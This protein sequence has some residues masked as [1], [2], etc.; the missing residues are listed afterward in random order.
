MFKRLNMLGILMLL[1]LGC[2]EEETPVNL[3]P[4]PSGLQLKVT[5]S[6][7]RVLIGQ[8]SIITLTIENY[9]P[10]I[11]LDFDCMDHYG[12]EVKQSNGSIDFTLP[13][14]VSDPH[15]YEI[16]R[17]HKETV[18]IPLPWPRYHHP[19]LEPGHYEIYAGFREHRDEY[20]WVKT[21]LV[22]TLP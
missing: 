2:S 18:N 4:P 6:P 17:G 5:A 20:P 8:T 1:V 14:C 15:T 11:V 9:G 13:F 12:I 16:K 19:G 10:D 3:T 21:S 22:V 7:S